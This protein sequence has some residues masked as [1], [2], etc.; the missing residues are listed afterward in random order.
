MTG[1]LQNVRA[2]HW[3]NEKNYLKWSQFNKTYLNDKGRFNHLLRTSPQ[4]EDSTFNAWDEADSIVMSWLHDSIDLT[5]SDTCM[6]LKIA[7]EI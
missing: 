1:D 2:T 7:K 4:L 6:F 5:L 3:L